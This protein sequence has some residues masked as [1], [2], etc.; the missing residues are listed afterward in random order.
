MKIAEK[1]GIKSPL[2]LGIFPHYLCHTV[3]QVLF[4]AVR[5]VRM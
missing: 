4:E 1:V 3:Y 5:T 2:C